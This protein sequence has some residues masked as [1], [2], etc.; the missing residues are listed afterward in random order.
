MTLNLIE[1]SS[2]DGDGRIKKLAIASYNTMMEGLMF[3]LMLVARGSYDLRIMDMHRGQFEDYE[4][5]L[6]MMRQVAEQ[7]K[8][9]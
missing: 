8:K 2:P 9:P 4:N 6:G 3:N 7:R 5:M 1:M